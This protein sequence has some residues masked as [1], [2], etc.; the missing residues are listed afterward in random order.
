M[1]ARWQY[2]VFVSNLPLCKACKLLDP[3]VFVCLLVA[4][5]GLSMHAVSV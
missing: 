4:K 2:K 1:P 5:L 3:C